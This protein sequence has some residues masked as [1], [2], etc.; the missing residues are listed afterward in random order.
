MAHRDVIGRT[1]HRANTHDFDEMT[2]E[3]CAQFCFDHDYAYAGT[4]YYYEC[5]CGNILAEGGVKATDQSDCN[6]PCTGDGDQ[7]C[8]GSDRLTL[9]KRP[10]EGPK[11]NPGPKNWPSIGCYT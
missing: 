11:E 6:M 7:A 3:M 8:G 4:E 10:F 2:N 9:Y 5:W 1:I